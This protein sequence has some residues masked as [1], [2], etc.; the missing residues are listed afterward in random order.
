MK[1]PRPTLRAQQ[2]Y[3]FDPSTGGYAGNS[4]TVYVLWE[5]LAQVH[6]AARSVS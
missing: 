1:V 3:A 5:K 2:M 6:P 4:T